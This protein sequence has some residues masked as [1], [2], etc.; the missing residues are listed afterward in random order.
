MN[1]IRTHFLLLILIT[2]CILLHAQK[3]VNVLQVPG[4]KEFCKIEEKGISVLPSGRFVTPAG[5]LIRITHDPFGMAISPDGKKAVTLH[6]GVF[7]IIDLVSLNHIRIPS[8][9][10]KLI[11]PL[12]NGSFLGV[13]FAPDSKTIYLIGGDN[14]AVIIYDITTFQRLDSISL[15]GKINGEEFGD[16]FTSDLLLNKDKNELLVL[17][18]GNFRMVRIDLFTKAI[19]A[20]LKV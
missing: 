2:S 15:N 14:G 1:K 3:Q 7:T 16:S 19:T 6:N 5:E 9:D 13:A 20:S 10:D 11:S 12:S 18:R 4:R 17:D 8:Y